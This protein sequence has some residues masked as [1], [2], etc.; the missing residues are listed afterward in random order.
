[1]PWA[2]A[3]G[4]LVVGLGRSSGQ[5]ESGQRDGARQ[6][7]P[8][9]GPPEGTGGRHVCFLC[10]SAIAGNQVADSTRLPHTTCEVVAKSL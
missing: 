4:A 5:P 1:L 3:K 8:G 9:N 7:C 6:H 10:L 2:P